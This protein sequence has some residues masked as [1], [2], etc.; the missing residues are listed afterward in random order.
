MPE[1]DQYWPKHVACVDES[2]EILFWL[3][4]C[5]YRL[6]IQSVFVIQLSNNAGI[7]IFD[8]LFRLAQAAVS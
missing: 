1:D 7:S 4:V 3:M 2:N 5:F 8:E 6:L